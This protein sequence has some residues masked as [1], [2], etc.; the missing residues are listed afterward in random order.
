M[1]ALI[2]LIPPDQG[3]FKSV[4][5]FAPQL[6]FALLIIS[7][8]LLVFEQKSLMIITLLS[9]ALIAFYLKTA[10]NTN[11][12][13]PLENDT[14]KTEI[15]LINLDDCDPLKTDVVDIIRN[16]NVDIIA[17][18]EYSKEWDALL[19][20]ALLEEYPFAHKLKREDE[21]G[22]AIFTRKK[23]YKIGNFYY[24][25]IPNL[26][27]A[28]DNGTGKLSVISS[29]LPLEYKGE[30]QK[31]EG[32]LAKLTEEIKNSRYPVVVLGDFN[33]MYWSNELVSFMKLADLENS[34]RSISIENLNPDDHIFY[35]DRLE[36]ISFQEIN[37]ND[38]KH[39]GIKGIY[40][41]K[42]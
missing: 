33:K 29:Y 15:I 5:V 6:M 14:V 10:S 38:R 7:F 16:T 42:N 34:R 31:V 19:N 23:I 40:Q 18:Q 3:F 11:L 36:C 8:I 24:N 37:D 12:V 28:V 41:L 4:Y 17:F 1:A 2:I 27:I 20:N 30:G 39:I 35:T 26:K 21:F 13:L 22:F 32:H 9:A 25:D